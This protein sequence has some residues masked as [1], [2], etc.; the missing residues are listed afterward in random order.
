MENNRSQ[1]SLWMQ[2]IRPFSLTANIIPVLLAAMIALTF[3]KGQIQWSYFTIIVICGMMF[4]LAG[5]LLSEYYDF[6]NK[7]DRAE[8]YGSS[9]ILV[10]GLL[11][12]KSILNAGR[13]ILAV[14]FALGLFLVYVRGINI[15]ILGMSGAAA[16]YFYTAKPFRLKYNALGD[17][18]IFLFFGPLLV[19]GAFYGLTGSFGLYKEII[20]ISIPVGFLVVGI[21]HANNTRDIMHDTQAQIKTLASVIGI[22][23]SIFEY[24]FLVIGAYLAVIMFVAFGLLKPWSL[25]VLVSL[26]PALKNLKSISKAEV[27]KPELIVGLDVT[28]A[29]HHMLFGLLY[30]ISILIT[31]F[32]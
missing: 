7:V 16:V 22:E 4:Q 2:A 9:R 28:T 11:P 25:L 32:V 17:L 18:I 13:L 14:G 31:K 29:Q 15:L 19:L 23:F 21:L 3:Y 24:Y 6:A 30:C 26:P 10:D 1:F 12:P 8:T 5:N 20:L 27:Q